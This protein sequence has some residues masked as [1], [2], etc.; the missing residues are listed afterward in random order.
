M[1]AFFLYSQENRPR[2]KEESPDASFGDVVSLFS[3]VSPGG[4]L[5]GSFRVIWWW[6][7]ARVSMNIVLSCGC[8]WLWCCCVRV[9]GVC[10]I[11]SR[12][13]A[14]HRDNTTLHREAPQTSPKSTMKHGK[15][16]KLRRKCVFSHVDFYIICLPAT[17]CSLPNTNA[18][19]SAQHSSPDRTN[20]ILNATISHFP[21]PLQRTV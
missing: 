5:V 14:M 13:A 16:H 8:E 10:Q 11:V 15:C 4:L 17:S 20:R 3:L 9:P 7:C 12:V 6:F 19:I 2:V 18:R 21:F 1:S